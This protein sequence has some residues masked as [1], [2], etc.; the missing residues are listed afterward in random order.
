MSDQPLPKTLS[1]F[2]WHFLKKEWKWLLIIQIFGFA[3]SL[4]HTIW[5]YIIMLFID[6][7]TNF[8]GDKAEI[9]HALSKPILM[10]LSLWIIVEIS[11]RLSGILSA[12]IFPTIEAKIRMSMFDYVLHHSQLYFSNQMAGAI[13]N[14]I[15]DMP[16]SMT[17]IL[18]QLMHLF[19][20]VGLALIISTI[21]FARI[22]PLFAIILVSWV[23]IHMG[24]CLAFSRK[25]D[26]YSNIHAE[27]R[28][29]LSGKIVDSLTNSTNVRLFARNRFE[30]SY[31]SLFQKDELQK[32]WQSL[33][34]IE[35][36]KIALGIASFLGAGIGLN[37]YMIYS[38]QQGH[39]TAGEVVFIFNTTWNITMMAWLAGLEL[40]LLFKEIG[41]C[42]Q[43]LTII[44]DPHDIIDSPDA[45]TLKI[46]NGEIVFDH[47]TFR[48]LKHQ[49]L[50]Q[51]KTITLKAKQK[52]GLV[53]F[54]GSGKTTFVNLILR[55]YDVQ[56]G[57]I[58]IDG[59]DISQVTQESLREQISMIPQDPTLFHR[60]LIEN[61]RYG[62][63]DAT[64]E[65]VIEASK[66]A[67][68]HEFIL[69]MP[70][71]YQSPVGERGVKLSGGQ[72]QRIA[73][74]RAILKRAP[75]LILDEATSAL[76]SVTEKDIQEGLEFLMEQHTTLV[77]A[78]RLS[79]LSGM[80]RILVFDEGKI[81][82]EGTHE[83][84][85]RVQGHYSRMWNMQV[86]GFLPETFS[87][88]EDDI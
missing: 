61:I 55:Y 14:K 26:D 75:I 5:P 69:K 35:K 28:S 39:L 67:H 2:F 41:I 48:Y 77:I 37:W 32:H 29:N 86:G 30:H 84:L 85:I 25:C 81:V 17:R 46:T 78:H 51:H 87:P 80:D 33:W 76:D 42:R 72:R 65:E 70:E 79:T 88:D 27:A 36:M 8:A 20:P 71:K 44:Q 18:Q 13:A 16:Q 34:Y 10:G 22:S 60:S 49:N 53:G 9:W 6:G 43:A 58:L 23:T 38:W 74:A 82:E 12:K 31:L 3:W 40:P 73:I 1:A 66:R 47:V 62:R 54:S 63:L 59:Q 11:F 52:V 45:K 56:G 50:F 19:L 21:L 24:I 57:R 15:S 64:D 7:I 68:C 83:E 4:D